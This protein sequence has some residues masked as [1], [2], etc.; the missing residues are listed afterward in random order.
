M[1]AAR[2]KIAMVGQRGVPATYG[3]IE[4]HVEQLG[5]RL[6]ELGHE[7]TVY[8]RTNYTADRDPEYRGMQLR[9]QSTVNTKHFDAIAQ[10]ASATLAAMS[11][12]VDVVH[13]HALG[14]GLV[15]PLP[16]VFSRAKVVQTVHGLDQDRAKWGR[17]ATRVLSTG[18]WMSARVPDA[19]VVVSRALQAEYVERFGK[20]TDYIPNG[21]ERRGAFPA[22]AIR[23]TY[24]LDA[25]SYV[26]FVGRLVPEKAPDLLLRA[27]RDVPTDLRLVIAGGSSFTD[28]YVRALE[29]LAAEDPR[30][31]LTGYVHGQ[32]LDELYANAALFVLPSDVEG[33][34]LTLLEAAAHG[35]PILASDI[36]PHLEVLGVD[37]PGRRLFTRGDQGSLMRA[38]RSA[39][40]DPGGELLGGA[41]LRSRIHQ[42]F[43]W[44]VAANQLVTLYRRVLDR[45]TAQGAPTLVS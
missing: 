25:G 41:H 38:V 15:S 24:G 10:S 27:F 39:L 30:V 33:M 31:I 5:S 45:K 37:A 34:P 14:P 36:P 6:V 17:F 22:D 1:S 43:S 2:L 16:R 21:V 44:D 11:Q 4:H 23:T 35:A 29:Q 12:G 32:L 13:Y 9:Y 26:L 20:Q 40:A 28:D 3:G 8:C 7:V 42:E 19:T 18:C